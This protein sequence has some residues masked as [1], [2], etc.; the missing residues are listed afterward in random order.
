MLG[1]GWVYCVVMMKNCY[2]RV[3]RF[4]V[5]SWAIRNISVYTIVMQARRAYS[6]PPA[7]LGRGF[8]RYPASFPERNKR[9]GQHAIALKAPWLRGCA[10]E[11]RCRPP[12][13]P[14]LSPG[15]S[16]HAK[17]Q[18]NTHAVVDVVGGQPKARG[19]G[20]CS[21]LRKRLD[22]VYGCG[23]LL[24]PPTMTYLPAY[25]ICIHFA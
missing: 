25:A 19:A 4:C 18:T 6:R 15:N 9:R 11:W 24:P 10:A 13:P 17:P 21:S 22:R 14:F 1:G 23:N 20:M 7:A 16:T 12:Y 8:L 2:S 3:L 5:T